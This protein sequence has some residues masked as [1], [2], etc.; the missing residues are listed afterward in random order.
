MKA[1]SLITI[2]YNPHSTGNSRAKAEDLR[3]RLADAVPTTRV[4]LRETKH[5]GHAET[6]AYRTALTHRRA[7][8]VSVSG[9]GGYNEVV[10]GAMRALRI[11]RRVTVG[12]VP[13]GNANDHYASR[14]RGDFVERV[15]AGDSDQGDILRL[16]WGRRTR[17][18]HSYMG[19][20]LTPQAGE[21]LNSTRATL[22]REVRIVLGV[23]LHLKAVKLLVD[24]ELRR[25]DSLV[26]SNV[27]RMSKVIRLPG[28]GANDGLMEVSHLYERNK[29]RLAADLVRAAVAGLP[30][31][32]QTAR[33]A[34]E[35]LRRTDI[36]ID[37]E[38]T[39]LPA[40]AKVTVD[41][42]KGALRS[43]V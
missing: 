17:Y 27:S 41:V 23:L 5:A 3:R 38:I 36:Q 8:V 43:I 40:A 6:I 14:H 26:F 33:F 37:G 18:G 42:M 19:V 31:D 12:L 34:F 28:Y 39:R 1:F 15:V 4:R 10:N 22:V 30:A 9:D 20:G 35:T 24:G 7:L 13:A 29:F 25:Y 32:E 16:R 2:V 21:R 11:G